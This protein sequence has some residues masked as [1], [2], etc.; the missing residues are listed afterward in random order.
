M[1]YIVSWNDDFGGEGQS[2]MYSVKRKAWSHYR[3]LKRLEDS[4]GWRFDP[5][6]EET[7]DTNPNDV[8]GSD[9]EALPT[10][11]TQAEWIRVYNRF[12]K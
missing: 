12:A 7:T 11:K 5:E 6:T 4:P 10:P 1:I 8:H 9:F 3:Q 2:W